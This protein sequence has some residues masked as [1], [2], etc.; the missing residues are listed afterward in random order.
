MNYLE[1]ALV[2]IIITGGIAGIMVLL[3]SLP[4]WFLCGCDVCKKRI[5]VHGIRLVDKARP[6]TSEGLY[7]NYTSYPILYF[8]RGCFGYRHRKEISA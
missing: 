2:P 3:V 1:W 4:E 6:R 5:L 7:F 8:H